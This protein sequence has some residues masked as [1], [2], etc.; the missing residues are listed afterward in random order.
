MTAKKMEA[1]EGEIE[2]LKDGVEEKYFRVEGRLS[3]MKN[4]FGNFKD[5]MK[6]ML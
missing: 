5:M 2:Q 6:N 1:L 3:T 4:C